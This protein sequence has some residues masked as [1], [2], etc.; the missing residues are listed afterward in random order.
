MQNQK[1][2]S[3]AAKELKVAEEVRQILDISLELP[4]KYLSEHLKD[5][6]KLKPLNSTNFKSEFHKRIYNE[7]LKPYDS[8]AQTIKFGSFLSVIAL[9]Q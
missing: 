8:R 9:A 5:R 4:D 1:T 3:F 2:I 7:V 6:F